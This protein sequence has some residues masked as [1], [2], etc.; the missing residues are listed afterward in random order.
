MARTEGVIFWPLPRFS[1]PSAHTKS[2]TRDRFPWWLRKEKKKNHP[3]NL[4]TRVPRIEEP[5][6]ERDA[7]LEGLCSGVEPGLLSPGFLLLHRPLSSPFACGDTVG[8]SLLFAPRGANIHIQPFS[9]KIQ[10]I[11]GLPVPAGSPHT[12]L[13]RY[14]SLPW[15]LMVADGAVPD[16]H[17]HSALLRVPTSWVEDGIAPPF[18]R[19]V[20]SLSTKPRGRRFGTPGRA[21]GMVTVLLP[22]W[23]TRDQHYPSPFLTETVLLA[24]FLSHIK[25]STTPHKASSSNNCVNSHPI[26]QETFTALVGK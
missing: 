7:V 24:C 21:V 1:F 2:S 16:F 17:F 6:Q 8:S 22:V 18:N 5:A 4:F 26:S 20:V 13:R 12:F 11:P 23:A 19:L 10:S 15:P 14:A 9:C 3:K 25:S